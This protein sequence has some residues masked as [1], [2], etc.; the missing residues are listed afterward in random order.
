VLFRSEEE[1]S[2]I[3]KNFYPV[4][5]QDPITL[6][7]IRNFKI[8]PGKPDWWFSQK[9]EFKKMRMNYTKKFY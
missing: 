8:I 5:Q 9:E 1:T 7:W 4:V 2:G 6:N 3:V